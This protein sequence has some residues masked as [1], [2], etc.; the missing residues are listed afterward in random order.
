MT[1]IKTQIG[2]HDYHKPACAEYCRM[3][4]EFCPFIKAGRETVEEIVRWTDIADNE[5]DVILG[6]ATGYEKIGYTADFSRKSIDN[7][8]ESDKTLLAQNL[9]SEYSA[10]GYTCWGDGS[11]FEYDKMSGNV[12]GPGCAVENIYDISNYGIGHEALQF[13]EW[14]A[15]IDKF[16]YDYRF[17]RVSDTNAECILFPNVDTPWMFTEYVFNNFPAAKSIIEYLLFLTSEIT[18]SVVFSIRLKLVENPS[19]LSSMFL[20]SEQFCVSNIWRTL[21]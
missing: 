13:S 6:N 4:G 17:G 5:R 21:F 16:Q 15:W 20:T 11:G 14:N 2:E 3:G 10:A 19:V 1:Y 7:L 18:A 8:D 12:M 9:S